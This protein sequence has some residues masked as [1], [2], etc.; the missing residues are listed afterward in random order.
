MISII[1]KLKNEKN[2]YSNMFAA[3]GAVVSLWLNYNNYAWL[4]K[5]FV[6]INTNILAIAFVGVY[7]LL[8]LA[9]LIFLLAFYV[10]I[11]IIISQLIFWLL[12]K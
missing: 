11:G 10:A 9:V 4:L 12:I 8:M 2:F 1:Q 5:S 6:M 3:V 7:W